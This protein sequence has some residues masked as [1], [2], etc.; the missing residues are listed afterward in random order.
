MFSTHF[1]KACHKG[2]ALQLLHAR[3]AAR[4]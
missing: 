1:T 2:L 3:E 4:A